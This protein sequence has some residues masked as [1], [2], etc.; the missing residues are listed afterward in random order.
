MRAFAGRCLI[1][2]VITLCI[3]A[4]S[5]D[6]DGGGSHECT[7][8]NT[9]TVA[10]GFGTNNGTCTQL[11]TLFPLG[12]NVCGCTTWACLGKGDKVQFVWDSPNNPSDHVD[13]FT[14]S[15]GK[16]SSYTL[17]YCHSLAGT[18]TWALRVS[19]NGESAAVWS[20]VVN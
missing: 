16:T 9:V 7:A 18:G 13:T 14:R 4:C 2:L 10:T 3:T 20:F 1:V 19:R 6:E 5:N 12:T 15:D 11:S 8:S 17:A